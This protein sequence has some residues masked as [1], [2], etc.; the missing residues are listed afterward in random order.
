MHAAQ[1][2]SAELLRLPCLKQL[3]VRG[4]PLPPAAG[5]L[6]SDDPEAII[7]AS[8]SSVKYAGREDGHST[9]PSSGAAPLAATFAASVDD[10]Q[11]GHSDRDDVEGWG[12]R[13]T[14][15]RVPLQ[16]DVMKAGEDSAAS[17][18]GGGGE[19]EDSSAGEADE[20][21]ADS[22]RVRRLLKRAG[23]DSLLEAF[24]RVMEN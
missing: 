19:E 14:Q 13:R 7:H 4:N 18:G 17:R 8:C 6:P 5:T 10:V 23:G 1:A 24:D 3:D 22:V 12:W 15:A 9:G 21:E 2:L 11:S 20:A 16:S